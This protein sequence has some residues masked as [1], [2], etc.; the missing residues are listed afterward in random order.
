MF[1]RASASVVGHRS[2]SERQ[3]L[4]PSSRLGGSAAILPARFSPGLAT[5]I[6]RE[7]EQNPVLLPFFYRIERFLV[8]N[9]SILQKSEVYMGF[10]FV[11]RVESVL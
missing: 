10:R 11:S 7:F 2:F 5:F 4:S 6:S 1:V 3:L 9:R 8:K